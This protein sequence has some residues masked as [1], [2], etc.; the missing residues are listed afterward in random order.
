[1]PL[2]CKVLLEAD[3]RD[4]RKVALKVTI[5]SC[6]LFWMLPVLFNSSPS[7]SHAHV[8][9]RPFL[10]FLSYHSLFLHLL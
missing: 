6:G 7:S 10:Y 8:T 4:K 5:S 3:N 1:M 9:A 2:F